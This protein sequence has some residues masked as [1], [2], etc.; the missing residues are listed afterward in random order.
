MLR[1]ACETCWKGFLRK[2][3]LCQRVL[4]SVCG[5]LLLLTDKLFGREDDMKKLLNVFSLGL[6]LFALTLCAQ[7]AAPATSGTLTGTDIAWS[8]D[9]V[10]GT[11]TLEGTGEIPDFANGTQPWVH[12]QTIEWGYYK[13]REDFTFI[14]KL[15]V[16]GDFT[17][18]GDRAFQNCKTLETAEIPKTVKIIG[19]YAFENCHLLESIDLAEDVQ[20]AGNTF[21]SSPVEDIVLAYQSTTYMGSEYHKN[22]SA[23]ALTGDYRTDIINIALSQ[24]GYHEG[25]S[26]E[27]YD[28]K[29]ASGSK[30]FSE[31]GRFI[32]TFGGEWCSEFAH[33]CARMAGVPTNILGVSRAAKVDNWIKDTNAKYYTWSETIYGGGSYVP[34]PGDLLQWAWDLEDHTE[35]DTLSHTSLFNGVTDNGDG[36]VTIHSIDGNSSAKVRTRDYT[37]DKKKGTRTGSSE[38]QLYYIVSPDYDQEV[39]TYRVSFSCEGMTFPSKTVA[40]KGRYGVLPLPA[41]REGYRFGWYTEKTGGELVN[42]Y[43]PVK[44]SADQ[45]LYG[46]WERI[47]EE[48]GALDTLSWAY[49]SDR[50]LLLTGTLPE[51]ALVYAVSYLD[52]GRMLGA[53]IVSTT[54]DALYFSEDCSMIKLMLVDASGKPMCAAEQVSLD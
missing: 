37:L 44:L 11:L 5:W 21:R 35:S 19:K 33:W 1:T 36:T 9:L 26:A 31:Y 4:H 3:I 8:Y 39:T 32:G 45:T 38:G 2:S 48:S 30:D 17:R 51:G 14:K 23:V 46:R 43:T 47:S 6:L 34:Q 24:L 12:F 40:E 53:Q 15:I 16:S 28:G 18:I 20:F 49:Y 13:G 41:E 29:N 25:D 22:L 42:M 54:D 50:S 27:D 7:A 10:S 52:S